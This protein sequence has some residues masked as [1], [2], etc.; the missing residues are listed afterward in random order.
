VGARYYIE[1]TKYLFSRM[2]LISQRR[3]EMVTQVS[4]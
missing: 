1:G 3:S 4:L 2:A